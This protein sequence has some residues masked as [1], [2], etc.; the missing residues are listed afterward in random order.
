M[1]V[2]GVR[3]WGNAVLLTIQPTFKLMF[4][5]TKG[6]VGVRRFVFVL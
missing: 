6:R 1:L 4:F 5:N 3:L 2:V